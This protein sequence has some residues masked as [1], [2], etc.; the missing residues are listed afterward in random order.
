M[1]FFPLF[2]LTVALHS[3]KYILKYFNK[4]AKETDLRVLTDYIFTGNI[5]LVSVHMKW[6]CLKL[7]IHSLLRLSLGLLGIISKGHSPV[8][9]F[10]CTFV[11]CSVSSSFSN[12][13]QASGQI[14]EHDGHCCCGHCHSAGVTAPNFICSLVV[15]LFIL[16]EELLASFA[17]DPT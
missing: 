9:L 2:N 12:F 13:L 1:G 11:Q 7:R 17:S 16:L 14:M 15:Y 10:P 6:S 5:S 4:Y 3:Y 8:L